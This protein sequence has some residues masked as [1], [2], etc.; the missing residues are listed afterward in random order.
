MAFKINLGSKTGKTY[1]IE[2]EALGL[3]DKEVGQTISGNLVSS[4]LDGYELEITGGSDKSGFMMHPDYDGF[5]RKKV[6]LDYGKGM[7]KKPKGDKKKGSKPK[8]LRLRKSVR[9]KII[10]EDIVQLNMKVLKEGTK[11]LADLFEKKEEA[12]A[13]GAETSN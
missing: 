5:N 10:S 12:P 7:H 1:K 6:L 2:A 3:V 11:S 8:G 4:D 9:G 13:E